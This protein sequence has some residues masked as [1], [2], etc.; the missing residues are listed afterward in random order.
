MFSK[1]SFLLQKLIGSSVYSNKERE[2]SEEEAFLATY[3]LLQKVKKEK[4]R[5]YFLGN[6]GSAAIASHFSV[7][8]LN[9]LSIPSFTFYE[10]S[11]ITAIANDFGYEKVFS[12]PL[13]KCLQKQDLVIAISSSGESKNILQGV[14]AAQKKGA[15]IL[16]L[17]GFSEENPLRFLGDINYWV[18]SKEY[19]LVES[20]HFILLH[21]LVDKSG[22]YLMEKEP[23]LC[24]QK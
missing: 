14:L 4:G 24:L 3:V 2:L 8:W 19:G 20:A 1:Q 10:I 16:T 23:E 22:E 15:N 21:T 13:E 12:F 18:P 17:S 6:G 5:A 11:Q 9:K 7:D